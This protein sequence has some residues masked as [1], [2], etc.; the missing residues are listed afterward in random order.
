[1]HLSQDVGEAVHAL[2]WY[3]AKGQL[4][5]VTASGTLLLLAPPSV[6]TGST[7]GD[8]K[9]AAGAAGSS[10]GR[11]WEAVLRAKCG[12]GSGSG[13]GSAT[14]LHVT[15]AAQHLL[16]SCRGHEDSVRLLDLET[17]EN[18]ALQLSS[19]VDSE[20]WS[21]SSSGKGDG[22]SVELA[23]FVADEGRALVAAATRGGSVGVFARREAGGLPGAAHAD[24]DSG[25]AGVPELGADAWWNGGDGGSIAQGLNMTKAAEDSEVEWKLIHVF[26]VSACFHS[27]A[28]GRARTAP[29]CAALPRGDPRAIDARHA[30]VCPMGY[31]RPTRR[32]RHL[33]ER[34]PPPRACTRDQKCCNQ[35]RCDQVHLA[36]PPNILP[37]QV[38]AIPSIIEWGPHPGLL[39]VQCGASLEIAYRVSL[40]FKADGGA[41]AVQV[42]DGVVL[43]QALSTV[44]GADLPSAGPRMLH[45]S[46]ALRGLDVA[47]GGALLLLYDG[48][49]AEVRALDDDGPGVLL[50]ELD[51]CGS[52]GGGSSSGSLTG[53]GSR[54]MK[55]GGSRVQVAAGGSS[56][57]QQEAP[58]GSPVRRT[59]APDA[60]GRQPG[61][62][63][64][65]SA[66][67]NASCNGSSG[68][69]GSSAFR[70]GA[71]MA[72]IEESVFRLAGEKVEVCNFAGLRVCAGIACIGREGCVLLYT[73]AQLQM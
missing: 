19:I 50:G 1:M 26:Q 68:G 55:S 66:G 16:A 34:M 20:V 56:R 31:R 36:A 57:R 35:P 3:A 28:T 54:P 15:W 14:N 52:S 23:C 71:S 59:T 10:S 49:R 62:A 64:Q 2:L 58:G 11:N 42:A 22:A 70:G 61:S 41:A 27:G 8:P 24:E 39:A 47:R 21:S 69:F 6:G 60:V 4:L 12:G 53:S 17:E 51:A 40:H 32:A 30:H 18:S 33:I 48:M 13:S 38:E 7:R 5:V 45:T 72:L 65:G 43:V 29:A 25:T 37:C 73:L 63:L 44:A 67:G 9:G 46:L